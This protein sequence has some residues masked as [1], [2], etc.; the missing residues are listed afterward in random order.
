MSFP[1]FTSTTSSSRIGAKTTPVTAFH[2][3]DGA[4]LAANSL[5]DGIHGIAAQVR[6]RNEVHVR[7]DFPH[8]CLGEIVAKTLHR[9]RIDLAELLG[10]VLAEEDG[11]R[12]GGTTSPSMSRTGC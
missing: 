9:F 8:L 7:D 11:G 5:E 2:G 1:A 3:S 10:I 4:A 6:E 12:L